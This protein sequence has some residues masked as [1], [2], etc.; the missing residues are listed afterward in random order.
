MHA[1]DELPTS[2]TAD[3]SPRAPRRHF[4]DGIVLISGCVLALC[5]LDRQVAILVA[6]WWSLVIIIVRSDIEHLLIPDWASGGI[7]LLALI[8]V[9]ITP[10]ALAHPGIAYGFIA[11]PA[12]RALVTFGCLWT[13]GRIYHLI[14]GREGLGFGDVKLGA[15]IAFWL[16]PCDIL[17]AFV[18]ATLAALFLVT[19][20]RL[21]KSTK[22]GDGVVPFGAFLA[23]AGWVVYMSGQ[24]SE[25]SWQWHAIFG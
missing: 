13:I 11:G 19:A 16:G 14:T 5:I 20:N 7:A 24:I 10:G 1:S 12:L 2:S 22:H 17:V 3:A 15:A 18:L 21:A 23:P 4:E 8:R 9:M 6:A 25:V